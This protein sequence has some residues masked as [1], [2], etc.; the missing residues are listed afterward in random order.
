MGLNAASHAKV[1]LFLRVLGRREDGFHN[2][3]TII[4]TISL[5]DLLT[6][7]R[8]EEGIEVRVTG[9]AREGVPEGEGNLCH[10]AAALVLRN[11]PRGTIEA[12]E[13]NDDVIRVA[14]GLDLKGGVRINLR[15][16]IPAGAGLGG[17]S[18]NA[19]C[20]LLGLN[21]LFSLGLSLDQLCQTGA[22]VGSDVPALV[23]GGT[24]LAK[25]RGEEVKRLEDVPPLH[26]LIL[27]PDFAC[28]TGEVYR[29]WDEVGRTGSTKMEEVL[30]AFRRGDFAALRQM[31]LNDLE[32]PAFHLYPQLAELKEALLGAGAE[33]ALLCGSGSAVVGVYGSPEERD[34]AWFELRRPG[35]E[36]FHGESV[37]RQE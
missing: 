15:K 33:V 30:E 24:V 36:I 18:S 28:P 12:N 5:H 23:L 6:L 27:K 26:F 16:M 3:E 19:A 10:K 13:L 11:V 25:G 37:G 1:N 34:A 4:Q 14:G 20:T 31:K 22:E 32:G 21:E 17:G 8:T 2:I 7:E 29:A 9:P 35:W